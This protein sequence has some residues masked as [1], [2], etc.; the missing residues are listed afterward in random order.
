[1]D[2]YQR[3]GV[4]IKD[5]SFPKVFS[6]GLEAASLEDATD[7]VLHLD[8]G[9]T[10]R[11]HRMVLASIS[12]FL[13]D[14]LETHERDFKVGGDVHLTIVGVNYETMK[15]ILEFACRG[16]A[17]VP[18]SM[19]E[20]VCEISHRLEIKYLRKVFVKMNINQYKRLK[21][22]PACVPVAKKPEDNTTTSH[23]HLNS[24]LNIHKGTSAKRKRNSGN[25]PEPELDQ[26]TP[27]KS[28]KRRSK[29]SG[30]DLDD[31]INA[32][33]DQDS[34][35]KKPSAEL[36]QEDI[37]PPPPPPLVMPVVPTFSSNV[38]IKTEPSPDNPNFVIQ[39]LQRPDGRLIRV[40]KSA[41]SAQE[42]VFRLRDSND[43]FEG[44]QNLNDEDENFGDN[45]HEAMI[46]Q[47]VV[48]DDEDMIQL[49]HLQPEVIVKE[50]T[51]DDEASSD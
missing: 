41:E 14:V 21:T 18:K 3:D 6:S 8:N 32:S 7:V 43:S 5:R 31:D 2:A 33:M 15:L 27:T 25:L 30:S 49:E 44:T 11:T 51:E 47:E 12:E 35:F 19:A 26:S 28:Q 10:I 50:E 38:L 42:P 9:Q 37:M 45:G 20:A 36:T 24:D 39:T 16:K 17:D 40:V 46:K 48:D 4:V 23:H 13:A 29:A 1:M 34:R 22:R